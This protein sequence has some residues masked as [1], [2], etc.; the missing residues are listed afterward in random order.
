MTVASQIPILDYGFTQALQQVFPTPIVAKRAPTTNDKAPIGSL[1]V[2]PVNSAGVAQNAAWILTSIINNSANW[3]DISGGNGSY[4]N[5]LLPYSTQT[6]GLIEFGNVA[7]FIIPEATSVYVGQSAGNVSNTGTD[8]VAVGSLALVDLTTGH[9][10]VAV[11][12]EAGAHATTATDLVLVGSLAG[13]ALTTGSN[14]VALGKGA[15]LAATT[16]A[17][18]I[19]IGTGA[20]AG[21][22][23]GTGENIAIG[24][25]SVLA[26]ITTGAGNIAIGYGAGSA[27]VTGTEA[28]NIYINDAGVNGESNVMRVT[29]NGAMV[30]KAAATGNVSVVPVTSSGSSTTPTL[31]GRVGVVTVTGLTTADSG[32]T[33]TITITNSSVLATSGVFVT[34]THLN[35]STNGANLRIEDVTIAASTIALKYSNNGAGAL[36]SGDNVLISFWVIS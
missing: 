32:G 18:N 17:S 2:E 23:T 31:N 1:W 15:L 11:G 25:N 9:D 5:I 12:Y 6:V 33:Q 26:G 10:N 27:L 22:T 36:G 7:S 13:N 14:N 3:A 28:G 24:G 16:S 8:N 35:A 4:N 34:L 20:L 19:A 21:V 30:L 29:S